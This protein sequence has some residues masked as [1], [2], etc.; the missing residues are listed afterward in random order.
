MITKSNNSTDTI[1]RQVIASITVLITAIL[2]SSCT[3]NAGSRHYDYK[4]A[5]ARSIEYHYFPNANVYY[6]SHR[7]VYHYHHIQR[8]WLSANKLPKNIRIDRHRHH[9][10]YSGDRK[11][12]KNQHLQKKHRSDS[13]RHLNRHNEKSN[14]RRHSH[15]PHFP[16][17]GMPF[18][19][20]RRIQKMDTHAHQSRYNKQIT[21]V[22]KR[23]ATNGQGTQKDKRV[24][25]RSAK[26]PKGN[27]PNNRYA[28]ADKKKGQKIQNK[29]QQKKSESLRADTKPGKRRVTRDDGH[30]SRDNYHRRN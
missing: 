17:Q 10:V 9:S 13:G 28:S 20:A 3:A 6:D 2:L 11:P 4:P 23:H 1:S 26:K 19:Q 30:N 8:G 7:R 29:Q 12:W 15:K 24:Y 16:R 27:R 18:K 22:R 14:E 5:P 21:D 25:S